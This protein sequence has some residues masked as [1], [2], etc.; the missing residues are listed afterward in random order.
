MLDVRLG[1]FV[2][3]LNEGI[4][5]LVDNGNAPHSKVREAT[6]GPLFGLNAIARGAFVLHASCVTYREK[7]IAFAGRSGAGKSTLAA[8]LCQMG[9][10]LVSDGLTVIEPH[11]LEVSKG[12][13][14]FKLDQQSIALLERNP[15]GMEPVGHGS[16]KFYFS[17]EGQ[18]SAVTPYLD[19][20]YVSGDREQGFDGVVAVGELIRNA[21]I[22]GRLP[23]EYLQHVV[24]RAANI[25]TKCTVQQ[26]RFVHGGRESLDQVANS[27]WQTLSKPSTQPNA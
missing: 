7:A 15:E 10:E 24:T 2:F 16:T 6:E 8:R 18:A 20:V 12:P 4:W 5:N 14:R 26:I 3:R 22:L 11:T 27:V 19:T 13:R 17:F 25:V 21:Y 9:A 1:E 23:Q